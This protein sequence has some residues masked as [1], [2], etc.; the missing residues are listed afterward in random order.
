MS[1]LLPPSWTEG[2]L[3]G[4]AGLA[5]LAW[6]SQFTPR[7]V[8]VNESSSLP[9]G[10]YVRAPGAVARPGAIVAV[11]PPP[12]ARAYLSRLGAPADARLLK[13]VAAVGGEWVCAGPGQVRTPGRSVPLLGHDRRGRPLPVWAECRRLAPRELFLLGDTPTSF[14]SRY[15]GP[16]GEDAVE[17]VYRA[18]ITW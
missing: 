3:L 11:R 8:L 6:S 17:G 7:P 5:G 4:L 15:F 14:D 13:R 12:A 1:R 18:A 2:A 16:A 9:R 10:L